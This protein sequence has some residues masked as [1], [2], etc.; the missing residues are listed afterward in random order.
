MKTTNYTFIEVLDIPEDEKIENG[1]V[2]VSPEWKAACFRCPCG[3]NDLV[4]IRINSKEHPTWEI[5]GNSITP[6]MKR[7]NGCQSHFHITNGIVR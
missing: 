1:I 4:W 6:S 5:K 2:Y 3:C 7:V